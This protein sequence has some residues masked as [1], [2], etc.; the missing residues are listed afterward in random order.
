M[1]FQVLGPL[2][3]RA[4]EP[5]RSTLTPRAAKLRVV[6]ATLLVRR[7]EIVSVAGLI[8]ELWGDRPP[9]T[10]KTTLQ[11]YVSQLRKRLFGGAPGTGT[12]ET[13]MPGYLLQVD[14]EQ[15]DLSAFESLHARGREAMEDRDWDR[16]ADRQRRALALWRGPLLSDTPHGALLG[17]AATR[18]AELRT[19]ALEQRIRA[20]LHQ[21]RH[22]DLV[23][24]LQGLTAEFP[25]REEF[26]A[27][28]MVALYR[29]GRQA[30]ALRAFAALRR[31]LVEELAIEPGRAL[32]E[33]H[34]RI[35]A[36]D[37]TLLGPPEAPV[38]LTEAPQTAPGTAPVRL[39]D[40]VADELPPPE[41]LFTGRTAALD[42][43]GAEL[44][45]GAGGCVLVTGGPGTGKTALALAAAHAAG[46]PDGRVLVECGAEG[47]PRDEAPLLTEVLRRCG[48]TGTL[49]EHGAELAALLRT[50]T[51]GRRLLFVLD[52][53]DRAELILPVCAAAPGSV[54]LATSRR[55]PAGVEGRTLR[56]GELDPAE[57]R[58][59]L[60][61]ARRAQQGPEA[62][63]GAP[64]PAVLD[65]IVRRCGALPGALRAAAGL[66]PL[67]PHW[68][69]DR[70]AERLRAED[71]RLGLLR[72]G[73]ARFARSLESAYGTAAD[74]A[75]FRL[76]GLLPPGPFTVPAAAALFGSGPGAAED[77]LGALLA[78]G[79]LTTVP[80]AAPG[81][82]RFR[83][84][85]ALRLLALERLRAE[86]E[87]PVLRAATGRLC[88][89]LSARLAA[90]YRG[91]GPERAA[92]PDLVRLLERAHD[93]GLWAPVVR[94]AEALT[95]SF[96]EQADWG[97]WREGHTRALDAARRAGDRRAEARLRRS[98]GDLAWQRR[99]HT[100][101]RAHYAAALALA[102]GVPDA[103][104]TGRCL[105]GLAEL[106][107]DAGGFT[108]AARL[109]DLALAA[110]GDG[111]R[112]RY[113]ARRVGALLALDRGRPEAAERHFAECL[114]LA[115]ALGEPRLEAYARRCLAGVRDA[116]GSP[117]GL[118]LRPGVWRLRPA[119]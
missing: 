78:E 50:L 23:G 64:D 111:G 52:G 88:D 116:P 102:R 13:R 103:E 100:A 4:A 73:S 27:H 66:L 18:L 17:T 99:G 57:A 98:L 63:G 118:E 26:H 115:A 93:L 33:L 109:L 87:A 49:P 106:S 10:A 60:L 45:A 3:V 32:Q 11:V 110:S 96:E 48:A 94:L 40:R 53:A 104:E 29:T 95:P 35:L 12:L 84:P 55:S 14:P 6:L 117:G 82:A 30:E 70:L 31:T 68:D 20:E 71:T 39:P 72:R 89:H 25:L 46:F 41:P 69:A 9:R 79:L 2:A 42:A 15:L 85:E 1:R 47:A 81:G 19:S 107:L 56:L 77:R 112:G 8:D 37:E 34:R 108:E 7:G 51:A 62:S 90:A 80:A 21:G 105:A 65:R 101:A 114:R 43:L 119:H 24:E 16:A 113:E 83:L 54:V 22:H 74:P 67:H 61:A 58:E 75:G 28:L 38:V 59:L 76:L 36:A 5:G 91:G 86:D 97:P 44:A 92:H